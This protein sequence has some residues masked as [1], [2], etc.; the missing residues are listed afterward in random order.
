MCV[1][2]SICNEFLELTVYTLRFK[3]LYI[4]WRTWIR[5][6]PF[7]WAVWK[8]Y[9]AA[10]FHF[11]Y[12]WR[13]CNRIASYDGIKLV[14]PCFPRVGLALVVASDGAK[15]PPSPFHLAHNPPRSAARAFF[16]HRFL[17]RNAGVSSPP[18]LPLKSFA[19]FA[20]L[21][22]PRFFSSKCTASLFRP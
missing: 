22:H 2:E 13:A 9:A 1:G 17:F 5:I 19:I 20:T 15:A 10:L 16:L 14:G 18:P 11:K 7:R 3:I 6:A 12:Q 8:I 21:L 4:C